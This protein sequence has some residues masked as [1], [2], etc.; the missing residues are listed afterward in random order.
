MLEKVKR[1]KIFAARGEVNDCAL[2]NFH[3]TDCDVTSGTQRS[4]HRQFV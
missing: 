3:E 4:L 2:T 1:S